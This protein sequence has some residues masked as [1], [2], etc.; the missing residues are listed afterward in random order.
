[1]AAI[2][3]LLRPKKAA[4]PPTELNTDDSA[5]SH[6]AKAYY[7][8]SV[9]HPRAQNRSNA[10]CVHQPNEPNRIPCFFPCY[11]QAKGFDNI[12]RRYLMSDRN[13]V[14][15]PVGYGS[16][17]I[18]NRF[19]TGKSG[20][21]EGRPPGSV[22]FWTAL[23]IAFKSKGTTPRK[24]LVEAMREEIEKALGNDEKSRDRVLKWIEKHI[25]DAPPED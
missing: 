23:S 2:G 14:N 9:R 1:M 8:A 21:P 11:A 7:L 22:N 20:N 19:K 12:P 4:I 24:Y 10:G 5:R 17:P 13:D 18:E 6:F 16:P 25:A 15:T 3:I